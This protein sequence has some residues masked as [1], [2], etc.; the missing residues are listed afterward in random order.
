MELIK[1]GTSGWRGIIA[2]DFT[3]KNVAIVS[4]SIANFIKEEQNKASVIVGY[5]TRYMSEDFAKTTSEILAG[6][7]IKT[8]LCKR[9]T[10]TPVIS[11]EIIRLGLS[12]GINFTASHNPYNYNGLKYS[13][14]W[15][16]PALPETTKKIE[17]FCV[18]IQSKDIKSIPFERAVKDKLIILHDP[19]KTYLK[20][21]KQLVDFKAIEKSKIKVAVDILNGTANDYLDALL[22]EAGIKNKTI[23]KNRDPLFGGGSPEPSE[24]NITELISIVKKEKY[25]LGLSTDGDADRFGIIDS[26]GNFIAPNEVIPVLLYHLNRTRNWKGIAA[27]SVMTSS[28]L[29][30]LA[31]K[32]GVEVKETPVGFKYIGEIMA[33]NPKYFIIGGEESGGLTIRGHIPEKDGILACLL[34]AEAVAVNKKSVMEILKSIKKL[35]GEVLTDRLNFRLNLDSMEKFKNILIS[36]TP[37]SIAGFPIQNVVTLDGHKFIIDKDSW[38]GF[39]LSGTE[40]VVRLYVQSNSQVKLNKLLKAGEKFVH[41]K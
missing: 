17:K 27:R 14:G 9:D 10:P 2:D 11:Y 7:G 13:P 30:K 22:D 33:N 40:P 12:G 25:K 8:L 24:K 31:E 15:G 28:L 38:I 19:R 3:Y 35:T 39:R 32:I 4:Q 21:I 1:F 18:Q 29:D 6:N 16:G 34:M 37:K 36:E 26:G 5:D 23:R 41:G 20:R